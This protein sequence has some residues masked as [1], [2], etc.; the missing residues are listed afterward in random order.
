MRKYSDVVLDTSGNV[1][2]GATVTVTQYPSGTSATVYAA[3][4]TSGGNVSP[5]TTDSR[6]YFEFWA[7]TGHYS[8]TISKTGQT[9]RTV[10]D[11]LLVDYEE[12]SWTPTI[13]S[14]SGTIT[15]ASATATYVKSGKIVSYVMTITV[16]TNGT[17]AGVITASFPLIPDGFYPAGATATGNISCNATA[18]NNGGAGQ[19]NIAKYDGNYPATSGTVIRVAGTVN[20]TV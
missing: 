18:F 9:T 17:G 10:S 19:I 7:P 1:I 11:V 16:T 2:S 4:S 20:V 6:G 15:T 13:A 5:L 8:L 14:S 12:T 3:D